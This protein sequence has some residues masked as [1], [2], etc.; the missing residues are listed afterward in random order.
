MGS[1][2]SDDNIYLLGRDEAETER[3]VFLLKA[4]LSRFYGKSGSEQNHLPLL[5][6]VTRHSTALPIPIPTLLDVST[7][8]IIIRVPLHSTQ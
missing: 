4:I 8:F 2:A 7:F 1:H 3:Y 5:L 6:E